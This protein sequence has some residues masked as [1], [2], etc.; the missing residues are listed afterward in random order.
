MGIKFVG[1]A[2]KKSKEVWA[3]GGHLAQTG[4]IGMSLLQKRY[5]LVD[6]SNICGLNF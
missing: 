4:F 3:A 2:G 1:P 6:K 5:D